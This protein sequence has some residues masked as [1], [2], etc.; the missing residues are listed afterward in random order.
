MKTNKKKFINDLKSLIKTHNIRYIKDAN[1]MF[2]DGSEYTITAYPVRRPDV[3]EK[4]SITLLENSTNY[5]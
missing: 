2:N 3:P 1:F 5:Y 4:L